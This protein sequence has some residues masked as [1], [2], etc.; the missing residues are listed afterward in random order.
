MVPTKGTVAQVVS[1]FSDVAQIGNEIQT[2]PRS[3]GSTAYHAFSA[4]LGPYLIAVV[5]Y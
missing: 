4:S 3:S 5:L 1:N 2:T